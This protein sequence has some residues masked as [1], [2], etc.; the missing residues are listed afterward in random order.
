MKIRDWSIA[1]RCS[2]VLA[3]IAAFC[4]GVSPSFADEPAPKPAAGSF[5]PEPAA[6]AG[7]AKPTAAAKST[8]AAAKPKRVP[9][10]KAGGTLL[11]ARDATVHGKK[12]RYDADRNTLGYWTKPDEWV[13]WDLEITKPDTF[14]V[15]LLMSAGEGSGGGNY[16]V[17]IA[18]QKLTAVVPQTIS[19][20]QFRER[21]IGKVK[22]EKPGNYTLSIHAL[23]KPGNSVMNLR[24]VSLDPPPP[25]KPTPAKKPPTDNAQKDAK[26]S[27]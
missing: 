24:S 9:Q 12:L 3:A 7:G 22:I 11:R 1:G 14:A 23:N 25:P 20:S 27:P 19:F 17:E 10:S 4:T 5:N 15:I 13:S 21:F 6:T 2:A 8:D 18:D 26:K 16:T